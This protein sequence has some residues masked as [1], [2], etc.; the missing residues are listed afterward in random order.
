[1]ATGVQAKPTFV[2]VHG[3]WHGG[4]C[5]RS[6]VDILEAA[7]YRTFAP[8]LTGLAE[9]AHLMS[10]DINLDTHVADIVG[11]FKRESILNGILC[12]H[13]YAGWVASAA[14]EQL[15]SRISAIVFV[16]ASLPMDGERPL[17]KSTRRKQIEGIVAAG[18]F[19]IEPPSVTEFHVKPENATYIESMLTPQ[20]VGVSLQPIRLTGEREKVP[21]K[22]YVRAT[23]FPSDRFDGYRNWAQSN[24][25]LVYDLPCGHEVMV[26]EPEQLAAILLDAASAVRDY[27]TG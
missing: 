8:T 6:V 12:A 26:D 21:I 27:Q 10:R 19:S 7:G 18:N 20:P 17:D 3:A 15:R 25:W 23:V 4:W 11:L 24:K 14:V 16:D 9:R 2:L 13:S 1:M 5:W 22:V